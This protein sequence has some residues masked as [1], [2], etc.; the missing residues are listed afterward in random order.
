MSQ[1]VKE[2]I[3]LLTK[4]YSENEEPKQTENKPEPVIEFVK[5][6][7]YSLTLSN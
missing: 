2:I 3:E 5:K 7:D 4:S 1:E 6:G